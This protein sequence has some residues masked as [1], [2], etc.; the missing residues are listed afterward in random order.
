MSKSTPDE[1]ILTMKSGLVMRGRLIRRLF[2]KA[3]KAL[4]IW[5]ASRIVAAVNFEAGDEQ[6]V[7]LP[8]LILCTYTKVE[9][10]LALAHVFREHDLV[11]VIPWDAHQKADIKNIDKL[12]Q[13]LSLGPQGFDFS[14]FRQLLTDLRSYNRSVVV[15]PAAGAKFI[16]DFLFDPV[17]LVRLSV[18]ANVPIQPVVI[19]WGEGQKS[20]SNRQCRVWVGKR[21]FISPKHSDFQD[22]FFRRRGVR[23]FSKLSREEYAEIATR[24]FNK[25]EQMKKKYGSNLS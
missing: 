11:L 16:N 1:T 7:S 24:I 20:V 13:M 6:M 10:F 22:I 23:K 25:F 14:F 9:D 8:T 21:I 17:S 18:K 19:E 2:F 12:H 3:R 4:T 15:A 5:R